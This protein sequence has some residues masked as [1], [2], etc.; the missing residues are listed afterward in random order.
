M[1]KQIQNRLNTNLDFTDSDGCRRV[2][3]DAIKCY[4]ND[5]PRAAMQLIA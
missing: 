3:E 2:F 4:I 5:I 1:V